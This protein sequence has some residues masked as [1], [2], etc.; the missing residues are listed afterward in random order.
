MPVA[1]FLGQ[2]GA[3]AVVYDRMDELANFRFAPPEMGKRERELLA[4]A[5][6]V[7]TGGY[8]L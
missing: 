5:D 7:F 1:H 3:V 8:R 4:A 6:V 2:F